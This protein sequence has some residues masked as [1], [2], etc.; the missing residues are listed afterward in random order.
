[1]TIV[2]EKELVIE[3][4][5][6]AEKN[7]ATEMYVIDLGRQSRKRIRKLRQGEGR[8][9]RDAREAIAQLQADGDIPHSS[10]TVVLVVREK[11]RTPKNLFG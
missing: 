9:M 1:M 6:K 11:E 4:A 2:V 8:L 7:E 5:P 3:S 10:T